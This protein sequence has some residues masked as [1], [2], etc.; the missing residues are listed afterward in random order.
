MSGASS[1]TST[2]TPSTKNA[3]REDGLRRM[4]RTPSASGD[5]RGHVGPLVAA[6]SWVCQ[7]IEQVGEKASERDHDAADDDAAHQ[8]RIVARADRVDHRVSHS[9]PGEDLLDEKS[10]REKSGK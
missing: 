2:M 8:E 3:T 10:A 7:G 4:R 5:S 1:P 9:R 6:K